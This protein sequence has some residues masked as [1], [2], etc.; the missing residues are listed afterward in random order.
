MPLEIQQA[1]LNAEKNFQ[2]ENK[3]PKIYSTEDFMLGKQ[4]IHFTKLQLDQCLANL[5]ENQAEKGGFV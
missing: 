4:I 5:N 2:L 1:T 3:Q